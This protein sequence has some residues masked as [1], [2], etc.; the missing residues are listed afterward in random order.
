[1]P[2]SLAVQS[3]KLSDRVQPRRALERVLS[4]LTSSAVSSLSSRPMLMML[5]MPYGGVALSFQRINVT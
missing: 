1:M 3:S 5:L 4:Q 2:R